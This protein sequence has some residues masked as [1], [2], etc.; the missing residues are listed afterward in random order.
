MEPVCVCAKADRLL[1]TCVL[2]GDSSVNVIA[3]LLC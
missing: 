3:L 2:G 1:D